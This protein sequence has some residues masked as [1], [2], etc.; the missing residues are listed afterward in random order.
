MTQCQVQP[1]SLDM[2]LSAHSLDGQQSDG[3][4]SSTVPLFKKELEG[5]WDRWLFLHIASGQE[6]EERG[7]KASWRRWCFEFGRR[8]LGGPSQG[9][10]P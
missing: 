3:H 6:G 5:Q 8:I 7:R 10:G 2:T 4:Q 9:K 1:K